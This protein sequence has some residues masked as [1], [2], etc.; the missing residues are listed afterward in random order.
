MSSWFSAVSSTVLVSCFSSPSGP[1][2]DRPCSRARRT[3]S[4]AA[5]CSAV[6]SGLIF[7]VTSSSVAII[8]APLPPGHQAQR[9]RAGNTVRS[10]GPDLQGHLALLEHSDLAGFAVLAP[11]RSAD[12]AVMPE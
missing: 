3:S 9:D 12:S 6:G 5:R 10:T 11:L 1:V 2:S 4:S 8:T 7:F